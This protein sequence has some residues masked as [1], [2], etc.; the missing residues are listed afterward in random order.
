MLTDRLVLKGG[1]QDTYHRMSPKLLPCYVA[2][3]EGRHKRPPKDTVEQMTA[4][5]HSDRREVAA[6]S[7]SDRR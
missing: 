5:V 7:R 2:E 6:L 4:I 1:F 3:F